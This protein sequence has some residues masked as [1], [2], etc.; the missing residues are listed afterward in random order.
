MFSYLESRGGKWDRTL[1]FGLQYL[2]QRYLSKPVTHADVDEARDFFAAHGTPFP[3]AG[4]R[5]IVDIHGG[6]LPIRI[7]A[8]SE[9]AVVSTR[10]ALLTVESLDPET[11]WIVTWVEAFLQRLWYPITVA[12]QSWHMRRTI[13]SYLRETGGIAGLDFKL[14][15]F[16]ARG[17]SSGETAAIGGAAHL[18]AGWQ[19]SDTIEGV[20]M[21]N[22]YYHCGMAA[23]SI[24]AAEHST[25]TSWGPKRE[26][27]AFDNMLAQFA[28]PGKIL[29]V[30]SDSYN[31]Y[32]AVEY[33]IKQ[34]ERIKA[35]GATLVIRPD[36][37]DPVKV[38]LAIL[39]MFDDADLMSLNEQG[40]YE[41]P[42][43]FRIIQGDGINEESVGQILAA[44]KAE[45]FS[46][47]NL[48]FG[49]GGALL[50]KLNR[51]DLKFAFKCSAVLDEYGYWNDVYKDPVDDPGKASKRGR[52]TL[53]GNQT[54]GYRTVMHT[55]AW[56][57]ALFT[58]YEL[59]I[60]GPRQ[61]LDDIRTLAQFAMNK[62]D[63]KVLG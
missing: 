28:G 21:A 40:Y 6:R 10:N 39:Y 35:S 57:D 9:G 48:A 46:A 22:R 42:P 50:Q 3:E 63:E 44:L 16:G 59:G 5:R 4:W 14:H 12:T 31:I 55:T 18:A 38:L 1:F 25:I 15:D 11:F 43:H 19:G 45:G 29:A 27:E 56:D 7:K 30:V 49:S 61:S 52:M 51:D 8:V 33:W 34:S 2:L 24:P 13:A 37:G 53:T 60:T 17:V 58:V 62:L 32:K 54:D 26:H 41:L 20:V 36:S 23:F 47:A